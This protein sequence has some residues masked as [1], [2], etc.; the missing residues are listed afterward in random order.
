VKSLNST[1]LVYEPGTHTKYSNA[2][3]TVV[4]YVLERRKEEPYAKYLKHVV[5]GAM[6]LNDS[7]FEPEPQLASKLAKAYMWTYDGRTF[8][9]PAFQ[10][11]I[12]PAGCL[13]TNVIDL[14]RFLSILFAHGRGPN[15]QVLKPETLEEMWRPQFAKPGET[16]GFGIGFR[17][18][19]FA[20]HRMVGHGGAIYGFATELAAL[21]D[22]KLGVVAVTTKDSS[23]AAMNHIAH[24]ALKLM[25]AT[26]AG[27]SLPE[28]PVTRP[29]DPAV[30]RRLDGR[31]GE[32]GKAV[33]LMERNGRL[34]YLPVHGGEQIEVRQAADSLILDGR[35]G[36][37]MK[38]VAEN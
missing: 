2:G 35:L 32:G 37:G 3:I 24:E 13:Y 36:Y 30:A 33:D 17:V 6:G 5:L 18:T 9:A 12:G 25:L 11:G 22:D 4:G 7:A 8:E 10:L 15:G 1:A 19:K 26:R 28:I 20:G 38:I 27:K 16:R 23:N 34:H 21:P 14:G 29:V 31:Y